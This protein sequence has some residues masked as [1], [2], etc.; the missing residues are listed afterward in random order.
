MMIKDLLLFLL[1]VYTQFN[2]SI[3]WQFAE[4]YLFLD[5]LFEIKSNTK[6]DQCFF[7][8]GKN[9]PYTLTTTAAA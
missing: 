3:Q 1:S 8:E 6:R 7:F 5:L 2:A 4:F 9:N